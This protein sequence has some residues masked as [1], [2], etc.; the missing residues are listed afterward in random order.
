MY[1][2]LDSHTQLLKLRKS[3]RVKYPKYPKIRKQAI[4]APHISR[5][6]YSQRIPCLVIRSDFVTTTQIAATK[7]RVLISLETYSFYRIPPV[8]PFF[9]TTMTSVHFEP[10]HSSQNPCSLSTNFF[11]GRP[12]GCLFSGTVL[13]FTGILSTLPNQD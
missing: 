4:V 12:T 1:P 10:S 11:L 13:R 7:S 5:L 3:R 9:L 8:I 2:L 6:S